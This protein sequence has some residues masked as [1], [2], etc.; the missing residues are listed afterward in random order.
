[1]NQGLVPARFFAAICNAK[2]CIMMLA[3]RCA[4][5]G[6]RQALRRERR[7]KILPRGRGKVY[8]LAM[9]K[10]LE[11]AVETV[12]GLPPEVQDDLARMLL[13]LAGEDQPVLQLSAEEEASFD[14]S[15]AQADR[16]EFATDERVR[17]VW[18]KHGL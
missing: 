3:R 17:A 2:V 7:L 16:G 13:Q 15:L 12:R 9:T 4:A 6:D 14:E 18:A 1:M 8:L 5:H 11:Q 10:L